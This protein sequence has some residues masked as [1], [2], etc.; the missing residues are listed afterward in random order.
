[1]RE[2]NRMHLDAL[3]ANAA[4]FGH[5][6]DTICPD[7]FHDFISQSRTA[8]ATDAEGELLDWS[9]V[10]RFLQQLPP[11]GFDRR[12]IDLIRDQAGWQLQDPAPDRYS[13]LFDQ[14]HVAKICRGNDSNHA[15]PLDSAGKF[16]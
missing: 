15:A 6:L 14:E 16:P 8:W 7:D 11:S 12:F 13:E 10:S 1:M 4:S 2:R 3:I 5:F 9:G